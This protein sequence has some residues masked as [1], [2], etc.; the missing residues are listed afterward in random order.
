MIS[1]PK[2]LGKLPYST[3]LLRLAVIIFLI[4]F[5][6]GAI[7][8]TYLP[9]YGIVM[10]GLSKAAVGIAVSAH[11]VADTAVKIVIGYLL[12][13][14]SVRWIVRGGLALSVVG[15]LMLQGAAHPALLIAGAAIYGV[16]VSP[17]WIVALS[18]VS[19]DERGKEM[20]LL[21]TLWLIGLGLGPVLLNFI[22]DV[23]YTASF[24]T[25]LVMAVLSWLLSIGL[26]EKVQPPNQLPLSTQ[27][28]MLYDR[29]KLIKPLLPGMILQTLA[30]SMLVPILPSF[31][32]ENLHLTNSQYSFF[33]LFGGAFAAIGLVPM[34]K[35]SDAWGKKWFLVIGFS[36]FAFGLYSLTVTESIVILFIWAVIIGVSYAAVL[37]AWNALLAAYVPPAQQGVGWGIFST[38]EGIGVMLGPIIGG[39]LADSLSM[40]STVMISAAIFAAIGVFYFAYPVTKQMEPN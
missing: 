1:F 14:L 6:R 27:F 5:V 29:M 37:P 15:L 10:L 32:S 38:I 24:Y 17:V 22:I 20:G 3:E 23:S 19:K 30:A 39:Y 7:L 12:D 28:R 26:S 25:L 33:L 8:I 21:Y 31:A 36:M 11:Y 40:Q 2:L 16:G 13:R 34:G 4:E 18:K 9:N 35:L